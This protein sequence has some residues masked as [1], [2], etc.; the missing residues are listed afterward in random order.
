MR[1]YSEKYTLLEK[2]LKPVKTPF[3]FDMIELKL[4]VLDV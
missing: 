3:K 4:L 2:Y 1:Q